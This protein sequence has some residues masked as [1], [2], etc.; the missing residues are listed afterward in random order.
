MGRNHCLDKVGQWS[1]QAEHFRGLAFESLC[2]LVP[3]NGM[4]CEQPVGSGAFLA[5]RVLCHTL[6]K[7]SSARLFTT[8]ETIVHSTPWLHMPCIQS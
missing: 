8:K 6:G 3:C 4:L 2:F 5:C 1:Y 7:A